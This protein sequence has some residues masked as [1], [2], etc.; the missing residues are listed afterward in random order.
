MPTA[1]P[2]DVAER[3][4]RRAVE[5]SESPSSEVD[6]VPVRALLEAADELG[7]DPDDVRRALAEERAGVLEDHQRP[8]DALLG[9]D[10]VAVVRVLS[11][12]P[13]EVL[14][15][16]DA[17]MRRTRTFR[18]VRRADGWSDFAR[19]GDPLASAQR[20]ARAARGHERLER[21]RRVRAMVVPAGGD[22]TLVALVVDTRTSRAVAAAGGVTVAATGVVTA[23]VSAVSWAP[24]A[25]LGLPVAV[26]G[27]V[28]VMAARK[29]YLADVDADLEGL[30]DALASG[31]EPTS[32][33]DDVAA[34][35][36]RTRRPR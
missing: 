12:D 16:L 31:G 5:L 21:V 19:R 9:P 23:G 36:L 13:D 18:R 20:A 26:A 2:R 30:L 15:R 24:W 29:G 35:L 11:G 25:W 1:V 7:M 34:R 27:G 10:R 33:L 22:R 14:D 8:G 6:D 3:V 28:G 32:V 4:L 17:W